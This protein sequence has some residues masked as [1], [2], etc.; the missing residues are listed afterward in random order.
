M[1][2]AEGGREGWAAES[3]KFERRGWA[4]MT[5]AK[6][7][8]QSAPPA[9][10]VHREWMRQQVLS[11]G[12]A[13]QRYN[14]PPPSSPPRRPL[15]RRSPAFPPPP[16]A[17]ER[18]RERNWTEPRG[19]ERQTAEA[20]LAQR[21]RF[22]FRPST[23]RGAPGAREVSAGARAA[24][25]RGAPEAHRLDSALRLPATHAPSWRQRDGV[26]RPVREAGAQSAATAEGGGERRRLTPPSDASALG[27]PRWG[28]GDASCAHI[29]HIWECG[30][31]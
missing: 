9:R 17:R 12:R 1:E 7:I 16:T 29:E 5:S 10:L 4:S 20:H 3:E 24:F 19:P 26:F 11:G 2:R 30:R 15:P 13:A 21:R 6:R 14:R 25:P 27:G 8:L 22:L 31:E 28:A 18:N 23:S